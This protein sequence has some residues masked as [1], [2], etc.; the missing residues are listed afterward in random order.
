MAEIIDVTGRS[1][2]RNIKI[3]EDKGKLKRIGS[4]RGGAWEV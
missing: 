3:L 2:E 1:I 4:D